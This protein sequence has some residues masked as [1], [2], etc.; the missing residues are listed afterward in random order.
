MIY[1]SVAQYTCNSLPNEIKGVAGN[2]FKMLT[3]DARNAMYAFGNG[4]ILGLPTCGVIFIVIAIVMVY[5]T[6]LS[7]IHI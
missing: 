7:L 3:T 4:Q 6:T 5:I 1:R 2:T